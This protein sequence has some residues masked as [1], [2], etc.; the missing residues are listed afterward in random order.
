M[1]RSATGRP[2]VR[3]VLFLL[4]AIFAAQAGAPQQPPLPADNSGVIPITTKAAEARKLYEGAMV[5]L[6]NLHSAEA[7]QDLRK[8]VKID[9]DFALAAIMIAHDWVVEPAEKTAMLKQ[10]SAA[11]SKVSRGEQLIVEWIV[12]TSEGHMVSA[13]QAMN[14]ALADYPNDKHLAWL[15]GVWLSSQQEWNRAILIFERAIRLDPQFA[16]PLNGAA[17]DYAHTGSFDKAFAAMDAY[18]K[19]LPNDANPQDSYAEILRMA[20]KFPDAL[21][22]YQASLKI[23]PGFVESQLGIADTYALM[24]DEDRARKEYAIAIEHTRSRSWAANWALNAAITYVREGNFKGAD[25]AFRAV[26]ANAHRDDLAEQEAR[27]YRMMAMYQTDSSV[28]IRLLQEAEGALQNK[29]SLSESTRTRE[30]A[31][32]LRARA[33]VAAREKKFSQ[34]DAIIKQIQELVD[35]TQDLTIQHAY[36][37]AAGEV[38]AAEGK[39]QDALSHLEE[40]DHNPL[41]VKVMAA[42]CK[43]L[44]NKARA[45]EMTK[46]LQNWHEP[47]LEQALISLASRHA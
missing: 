23:D 8:A 20:G 37:G 6:E 14:E 26:A 15:A 33:S 34:A 43:S 13:I 32:I 47:T 24:G 39:F 30:L 41:S 16:A 45:E 2:I 12:N 38:L 40:D 35:R 21:S 27:A 11:K 44:G 29:H 7:V 18:I 10:A 46:R 17:Y 19:L 42:V 4:T 28:A 36:D 5:K 1:P 22:H 25:G 9:P 31:L 3:I